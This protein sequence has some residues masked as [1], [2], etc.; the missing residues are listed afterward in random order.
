M[1]CSYSNT[2]GFR[3]AAPALLDSHLTWESLSLPTNPWRLSLDVLIVRF[4]C[5]MCTTLPLEKTTYCTTGYRIH[6]Q[7]FTHRP[8]FCSL[9]CFSL[10]WRSD[11]MLSEL[12]M[13]KTFKHKYSNTWK[14]KTSANSQIQTGL[15]YLCVKWIEMDIWII[16]NV[17]ESSSKAKFCGILLAC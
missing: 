6:Q 17:T 8:H 13:W 4:Q 12:V 5:S 2:L 10:T 7:D 1:L 16:L 14:A 9:S 15:K 3:A 11:A